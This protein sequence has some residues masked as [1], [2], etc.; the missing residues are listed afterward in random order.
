MCFLWGDVSP[1]CWFDLGR[2]STR[3]LAHDFAAPPGIHVIHRQERAN[4]MHGRPLAAIAMSRLAVRRP[5]GRKNL[6]YF[7]KYHR[8][9]VAVRLPN[10]CR[11]PQSTIMKFFLLMGCLSLGACAAFVT[12]R[13]RSL[14]RKPRPPVERRAYP[15]IVISKNP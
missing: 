1:L 11:L 6:D 13:L 15:R 5:N 14:H 10:S 12:A 9:S 3:T 8:R 2:N 4:I 7:D